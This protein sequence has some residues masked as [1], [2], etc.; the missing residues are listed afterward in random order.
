VVAVSNENTYS[1][2]AIKASPASLDHFS[3][4]E[5]HANVYFND[6]GDHN[7]S[8]LL[9]DVYPPNI[10]GPFSSSLEFDI[11]LYPYPG[12]DLISTQIIFGGPSTILSYNRAFLPG[13]PVQISQT[14]VPWQSSYVV[15]VNIAKWLTS[16][17]RSGIVLPFQLINCC[18]QNSSSSFTFPLNIQTILYNTNQ[19]SLAFW[20]PRQSY[21]ANVTVMCSLS[22]NAMNDTIV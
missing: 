8:E 1:Q 10:S 13:P 16:S 21:L 17:P 2:Q 11:I 6:K 15:S 20:Q 9:L 4:R 3:T 22:Q 14:D 7:I 19:S 18:P 5:I 12:V